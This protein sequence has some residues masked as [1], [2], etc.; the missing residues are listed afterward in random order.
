[1]RNADSNKNNLK[2]NTMK[3]KRFSVNYA[4]NSESNTVETFDSITE[5]RDYIDLNI[6][7]CM[8]V[9]SR[10]TDPDFFC[11]EVYDNTQ[12][13]DGFPHLVYASLQYYNN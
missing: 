12:L 9:N 10:D 8:E 13:I 6:V 5:A 7:D 4:T 3:A 2:I 11:Y 1:M